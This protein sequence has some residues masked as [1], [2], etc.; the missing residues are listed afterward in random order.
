MGLSIGDIY[1]RVSAAPKPGARSD[2]D[3]NPVSAP[4]MDGQIYRPAA[5]LVPIVDRQSPHILLTKR[6]SDLPKHA[7]QVSF[8]GGRI[9]PGDADAA[10]AALRETE[11]EVGIGAQHIDMIGELD[12]YRT[13]TGFEITP[14]IGVVRPDFDLRPEPGEVDAVF[15][16][17]L[18]FI[19]N[20]SNHQLQTA[21]WK[22]LERRYYTMP[23]DGYHIWGATA[24]MLVN[25]VDILEGQ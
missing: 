12:R 6:S 23:Y 21:M 4:E 17:P 18:E 19:M 13:G 3:L 15:E 22:G 9:D 5:V 2:F 25:L 24:A 10:A 7:G 14:K 1:S 16:V 8:P 11:E 20:R